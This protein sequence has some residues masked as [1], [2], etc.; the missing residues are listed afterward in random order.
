MIGII[1]YGA[2]NIQSVSNAI[3]AVNG[4]CKIVK[5]EK[6]LRNLDGIILPGVGSFSYIDQIK[7]MKKGL[8]QSIEDGV[9]YLGICLGLQWLFETSEEDGAIIGLGLIGGKIRKF[10]KELGFP[11]PQIGWNKI[12]VK[13]GKENK[14]LEGLD[15]CYFYFVHSYYAPKNSYEVATTEYGLKFCSAIEKNN[16]YA[17]QFHPE[18]SGQNGL[19]VLENF[20]RVIKC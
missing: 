5:N 6:E 12:S 3:K 7:G 18:K 10:P 19:K 17:T 9:P 8:L 2:G 1:D 15:N 14:I 11:V 13:K 16:V 4:Q 20:L